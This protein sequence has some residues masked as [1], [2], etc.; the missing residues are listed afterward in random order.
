MNYR[1]RE[2]TIPAHMLTPL[3]SYIERGAPV[4]HFLTAVLE[5]DLQE[6]CARGD[7]EN[8]RNLPAYA[9]YLYNE[10]P[11][12]CHGSREHVRAWKAHG[13]QQGSAGK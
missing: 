9:A 12:Q 7:S 3:L 6:A 8:L 5:N 11:S 2:F 10:A 13:G 1:Y 4:G